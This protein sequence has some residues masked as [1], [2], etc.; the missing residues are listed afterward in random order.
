MQA[1]LAQSLL[2]V[3]CPRLRNESELLIGFT[4]GVQGDSEGVSVD[5]KESRKSRNHG[6]RVLVEPRNILRKTFL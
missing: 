5:M 1:A 4:R 3:L 2:F 6:P